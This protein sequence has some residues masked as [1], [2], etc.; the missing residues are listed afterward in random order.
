M[1]T[2]RCEISLLDLTVRSVGE[3]V[4]LLNPG[5]SD[6]HVFHAYVVYGIWSPRKYW[7]IVPCSF[8]CIS[9]FVFTVIL[10]SREKLEKG[11]ENFSRHAHVEML[12]GA[13]CLSG[14][15]AGSALDPCLSCGPGG[16]P[17]PFRPGSG[18]LSLH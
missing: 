18:I 7:Y 1:K 9:S 2:I 8:M 4:N 10:C 14:G 5:T 13:F 12:R 16:G 11:E 6:E 15:I 3:C 17:L